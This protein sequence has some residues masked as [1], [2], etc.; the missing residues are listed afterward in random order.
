MGKEFP[1]SQVHILLDLN[2]GG[3]Q[4]GL[5]VMSSVRLR[6]HP[7]LILL[8]YFSRGNYKNA[9]VCKL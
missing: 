3:W 9:S 4:G 6:P 7:N 8:F 2:L 1:K 5:K